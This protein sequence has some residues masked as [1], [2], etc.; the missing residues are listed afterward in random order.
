[1]YRLGMEQTYTGQVAT[2]NSRFNKELVEMSRFVF[3]LPDVVFERGK[4]SCQNSD[5]NLL[6]PPSTRKD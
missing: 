5:V 6:L 1:M 3:K 4:Y 2:A